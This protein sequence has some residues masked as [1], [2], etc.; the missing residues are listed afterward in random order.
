VDLV[1]LNHY[2]NQIEKSTFVCDLEDL[3]VVSSNLFGM[4]GL[5][6]MNPISESKMKLFLEEHKNYF[7]IL[8]DE[9]IKKL[10]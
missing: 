7:R 6:N 2:C 9:H 8:A 10:T 1:E 4:G 5:L 3:Q